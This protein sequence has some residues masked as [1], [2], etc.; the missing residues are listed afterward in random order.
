MTILTEDESSFIASIMKQFLENLDEN[1]KTY[2][3]TIRENL[4]PFKELYSENEYEFLVKKAEC[5][6]LE[7]SEESVTKVKKALDL[8]MNRRQDELL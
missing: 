7:G 5:A 2:M 6:L 4:A 3:A 1:Q 8:L